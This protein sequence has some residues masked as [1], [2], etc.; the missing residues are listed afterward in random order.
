MA[1]MAI[2]AI[3]GMS[4]FFLLGSEQPLLFLP[5]FLLLLTTVL[6]LVRYLQL[7]NNILKY[8]G[9]FDKTKK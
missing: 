2:L 3:L 7:T 1:F 4:P 6:N 8:I 9:F 5:P